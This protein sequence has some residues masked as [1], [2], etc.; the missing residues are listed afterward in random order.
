MRNGEEVELYEL[1]IDEMIYMASVASRK[2]RNA[3]G[4]HHLL[5]T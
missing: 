3:I 5:H 1:K 2:H 4:P